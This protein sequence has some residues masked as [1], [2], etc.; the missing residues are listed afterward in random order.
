[1]P[2][3]FFPDFPSFVF[4]SSGTKLDALIFI[5]AVSRTGSR[6]QW[7]ALP[8]A[9]DQA[10]SR[11][12]NLCVTLAG[13]TIAHLTVPPPAWPAVLPHPSSS[14]FVVFARQ[15][16]SKCLQEGPQHLPGG[17][18]AL[19]S[20]G[21]GVY[22]AQISFWGTGGEVFITWQDAFPGS[23]KVPLSISKSHLLQQD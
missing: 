21:C 19:T 9:A 15:W 4:Q 3:C 12:K 1:M 5:L 6:K 18:C 20:Q 11:M 10:G 14:S 2:E 22:Q 7:S 8:E 13:L 16:K 23:S 17:D